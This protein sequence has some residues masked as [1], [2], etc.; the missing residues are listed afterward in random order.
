MLS[1]DV[2]QV[3]PE[4]FLKGKDDPCKWR[5]SCE[6]ITVLRGNMTHKM[7]VESGDVGT[8]PES[9]LIAIEDNKK[10]A[11]VQ[12]ALLL[13]K[14]QK[15]QAALVLKQRMLELQR[16][17]EQRLREQQQKDEKEEQEEREEEREEPIF[18]IKEM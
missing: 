1:F 14:N 4:V 12:Q 17:K 18:K 3:L 6:R 2:S 5:Q 7:I 16:G 9:A 13:K 8:T 11:A 10:Q 15:K